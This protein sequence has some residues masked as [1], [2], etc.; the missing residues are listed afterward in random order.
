M[1]NNTTPLEKLISLS[2]AETHQKLEKIL[3]DLEQIKTALG[4]VTEEDN[5]TSEIV[6]PN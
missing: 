4:C 3:K 1:T 6:Y 5:G 2:H